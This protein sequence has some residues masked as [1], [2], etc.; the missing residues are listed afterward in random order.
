VSFIQRFDSVLRLNLYI[1]SLVIEGVYAAS[2]DDDKPQFQ[3]LPA[4]DDEEIARLTEC[5]SRYP[6]P[7]G[8]R[9]WRTNR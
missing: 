4:P 8:W 5:A 9:V 7:R 1:H 2:D 6:A 3:V